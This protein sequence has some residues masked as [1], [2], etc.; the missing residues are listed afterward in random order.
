M[1]LPRRVPIIAEGYLSTFDQQLADFT[2]L[3]DSSV[4]FDHLSRRSW[5]K[6]ASTS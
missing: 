1:Y 2:I 6:L 3:G 4:F 5:K